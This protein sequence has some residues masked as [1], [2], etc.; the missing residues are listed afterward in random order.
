MTSV[1]CTGFP[2]RQGVMFLLFKR[3]WGEIFISFGALIGADLRQYL[4]W[5]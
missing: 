2:G 1:W 3:A 5:L 4:I